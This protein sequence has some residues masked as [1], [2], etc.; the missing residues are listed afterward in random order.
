MATAVDTLRGPSS[1]ELH[2]PILLAR[3]RGVGDFAGGGGGAG[4]YLCG[5]ALALSAMD[6][7]LWGRMSTQAGSKESGE[8][9]IELAATL[10]SLAAMAERGV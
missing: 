8:K 6:M 1:H 4:G 2:R 9:R 5:E 10:R 7:E 3:L